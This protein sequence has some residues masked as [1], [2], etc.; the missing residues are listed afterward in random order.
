MYIFKNKVVSAMWW[1]WNQ[2]VFY[3]EWLGVSR[4]MIELSNTFWDN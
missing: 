2:A 4:D 1:Y 3:E